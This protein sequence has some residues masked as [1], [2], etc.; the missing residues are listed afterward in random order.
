MRNG[1]GKFSVEVEGD[2]LIIDEWQGETKIFSLRRI[3]K[4][5]IADCLCWLEEDEIMELAAMIG[6]RRVARAISYA[7]EMDW[8]S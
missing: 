5:E 8:I 2:K 3:P 6:K 7:K 4:A 1:R